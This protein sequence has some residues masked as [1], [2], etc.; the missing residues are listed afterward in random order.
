MSKYFSP[1]HSSRSSEPSSC[2]NCAGPSRRA[3]LKVGVLGGLGLTLGDY[4]QIQAQ[5]QEAAAGPA[6]QSAIFIFIRYLFYW[7]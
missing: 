3:F 2:Q 4:F 1:F 5:A 7:L 6:A